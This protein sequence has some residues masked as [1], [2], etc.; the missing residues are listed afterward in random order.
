MRKSFTLLLM[1]LLLLAFTPLFAQQ[2]SKL[3][4]ALRHLEK[5]AETWELEAADLLDVAVSDEYVA[6][7][8]GAHH[9]YFIQRYAGIP[10][11]TAVNGVH[12]NRDGE[13]VF[14]TNNFEGRLAERVNTRTPQITPQAAVFAMLDQVGISRPTNLTVK[15]Q[16]VNKYTFAAGELAN[17]DFDVQLRYY[18]TDDTE[19]IRLAWHVAVDVRQS[20]DYWSILIDAVNGKMLHQ[21]NYTLYCSFGPNRRH[22]HHAQ[23]CAH[24]LDDQPKMNMRPVSMLTDGAAY[25]V[26]PIP[27]ESPIHGDRELVTE[28]SDPVASPYGWHDTDGMAGAEYTIT[29]GN[30]VHA[31][32]DSANINSSLGDEP[33]GGEDLFFDF[34]FDIDD[35]PENMQES[36]VTQLFYMN[37][38]MHDITYAYGFTEEAGNF[39]QRNYTGADGSN[40]AVQAEAQDGSG[41]NNANFSTPPDGANGR[42]QMYQW[43]GVEG[44]V[45]SFSSPESIA[46]SF[47]AGTATYGPPITDVPVTGEVVQAFDASG[48]PNLVCEAVDNVDDIAGKI[49]LID[50]GDC[51][52]EEKTN[53]AEAAGAI[54]VIICNYL[55]DPLGMSGGVETSEPGIITVSLGAS[56][57]AQI[58]NVLELGET[59]TATIVLP[60]DSGPESV[61][62]SMDNGVIAHEYGHG[63][64]NRLT[65]GRSLSNCLTNSEQQ[66]EGWS[67]FFALITSVR[68]GD[69]GETLRGIGN[70]SDRQPS[71]GGGIR[72]VPY[73]TDLTF[74]DHTMD[75]ILNTTAPHPLG[76]VWATAI[77]DLYWAMVDLYGYDEDLINGD[78]GNNM[79][80]QLVMDGMALQ[81]CNPGFTD[82]RD[83]LF[84]ADIINYDGIHEC[85]IW[86]VFARRGMGEDADQGV[87]NNRNDNR[88]G[89]NVPLECSKTLKILKSADKDLIVAGEDIEFTLTVRNDKDDD[90]TGVIV[91]DQLPAGLTYIPGSASGA[92]VTDNGDNLTFDIG[93]L[94]AGD[95]VTITYQVMSSADNRSVRL[96]YDGIE[97]GDNNWE[98]EL[99]AGFNIWDISDANPN[100]GENSWFVENTGETNDQIIRLLEPIEVN[101]LINPTVR[102]FHDYDTQPLADGG[103]VEISRNGGMSWETVN[104]KFI[105]NDYRGELAAQTLFNPNFRAFW[106]DSDGYVDSY[107]DLSDYEGET[108]ELRFRFASN[109]EI[110]ATGWY[111]DDFEI[112][113]K[114]AY[115][116]EACVSSNEG[117]FDCARVPEGGVI[118][119]SEFSSSTDDPIRDPQVMQVYPNPTST[120]LNVALNMD[121]SST[122]DIQLINAAGAVVR[123]WRDQGLQGQLIS[124]NVSDL[125][126]GFYVLQVNT[127]DGIYT[128]KVTVQ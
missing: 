71:D 89:F 11:Y 81:T 87:P 108:I 30:N 38:M 25:N 115:E 93:D 6:K 22:V 96:F 67:D 58:K 85:L 43:F 32:L 39:Q 105:R 52:F 80:I 42:M 47:Q 94:A 2:Q 120:M 113:D 103:L 59:V 75:D 56:D 66:G 84:G 50:R 51:F 8:N 106:G 1:P 24:Q 29:R 31:Y 86:E 23:N 36:A 28:P 91:E 21:H 37:N 13:I 19:E 15:S 83:A 45:L 10:L 65:G 46:G 100:S 118:V 97:A 33:D 64:S 109:G 119:D 78:G 90:A 126:T 34:Y 9:F 61:G 44:S 92:D 40:D 3:D 76:E 4:Q 60:E 77:W 128:E 35:E 111:V 26:F 116:G 70:Y 18:H 63:I 123:Q 41:T 117:D 114:V 20:P 27:V 112:M 62:S 69:T 55:E 7:H 107:I 49:A 48:A 79:A 110:G 73:T 127:P 74:N 88:V 82:A 68:P 104:D 54:A 125:P 99:P 122:I 72:R 12:F 98:I 57:C 5:N 53:N 121:L 17:S 14:T 101:G 95:D 124:L 16:L 102:F